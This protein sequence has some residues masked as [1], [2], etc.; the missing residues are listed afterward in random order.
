MVYVGGND[1]M[2]HAFDDSTGPD[3]GKE[4][5]AFVP[6]AFYTGGNPNDT[7]HTPDPAYQLGALSYRRGG[8]PLFSHKFYVNATPRAWDVDFANTNTSTPPQSG[9][10]WRTVLVGGLGAGG[11]SVYALDITTPPPPPIPKRRSQTRVLW[12]FTDDDLGYVFDPP[13]LVKTYAYGWVVLVT[14]GYNNPGGKGFLYVLN[15]TNGQLVHPLFGKI[16]LLNDSGTDADPT[17]LSTIRAYVPSRRDPYVLQAYSG[18]LRGNVW[19]FDLADANP[20]NW[21]VDLIAKLTDANGTV[22]PITTGVRIEIDQTKNINNEDRYL[23]VGTGKLLG[24][25]DIASNTVRNTLYVI[26][27]GTRTTAEAAPAT[28]YSRA[29][30][31]SVNGAGVAGFTG[32]PTGRGWYQDAADLTEKI[33]SDVYADVQTVVWSF[34]KPT[35]DPCAAPISSRLYA[36]DLNLGNSVLEAPSGSIVAGYDIGSGIAGVG[37]IQGQAGTGS[38]ASGDIRA[39]VTTMKGEVFSFGIR[40]SPTTSAKHRVSW[41]LL[42]RD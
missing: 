42:N 30:L 32:A 29:S 3:Q 15:P 8:I 16:P 41:R 9:N 10:D 37:L 7:N 25:S 12:E 38:S 14:S 34:S 26:R 19:R 35:A 23:F 11:R 17:G 27:D 20:S 28:P 2:V 24:P 40:L 21:R 18:D 6:K 22:Q 1:G 39:L 13:T 4:S 31:N 5:W 36:R 33:G